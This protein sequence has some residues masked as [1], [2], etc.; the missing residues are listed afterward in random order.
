MRK[1]WEI[2]GFVAAAVL[3]A[4]GTVS[5]VMSVNGRNTVRDSLR[6]EQIVGTPDMT[7]T[8]IAAEA[9]KAGIPASVE[10]PTANIAGKA[11]VTGKL[12]REFAQYMRIHALEATGGLSYA[13]MTRYAT[14][15]GK[16]TN[17]AAAA[18]KGA[19]GQPLDN[20]VR[21]VWVT[22]TA[23]STALN[24]SYLAEQMALFGVVVGIA[25]LLTGFGLGILAVG[26]TLR[27]ADPALEIFG[28]KRPKTAGGHAP[29]PTA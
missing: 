11:I 27:N 2:G 4:F 16:G 26:G 14:A 20:P 17:D 3:I 9:M 21:T 18:L 10:L 23:L 8:T 19:N 12:A 25:L 7:K 28:R 29:L 15:N 6:A 24:T 13:Q 5:I 1:L 22:E